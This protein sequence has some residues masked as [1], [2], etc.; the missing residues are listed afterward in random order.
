MNT[1]KCIAALMTGCLVA[2]PV[3]VSGAGDTPKDLPQFA[4]DPAVPVVYLVDL[5]SGAELVAHNAGRRFMPASVTKVMTLFVA[6]EMIAAGELDP[7]QQ[8]V[9]SD[10]V[11]REWRQKGSTMF[12]EADASVSVSDL[13]GGIANVSANDGAMVLAEGAGGS[14]EAWVARMNRTAR[15]LGMRDSRFGTPNGWADGGR[16]FTT[17]RDLGVL[18]RAMIERH[19]ELYARY[20]GKPGFT[21]N[22][23]TQS[24]HDPISGKVEGADGIKTGFTSEAGNNFLGS[25]ERSGRRLVLVVAGAETQQGRNRMARDLLEWGFATTASRKLYPGGAV[26]G[27]AMVQGGD[28]LTVPLRTGGLPVLATVPHQGSAQISLSIHYDGPLKA[29]VRAGEKV[30]ELEIAV[31]GMT[32]SRVPLFAS[33]SVAPAKGLDRLWNG[34]AG[35]VRW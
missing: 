26:V 25:A 33:N 28:A 7:Q 9:I 16:T 15:E 23:I 10:A 2:A 14:V 5:S 24:N 18:A 19:P 27:T 30:A 8:F 12:I 3:M 1:R 6:F 34:L 21:Y 20:I 35:L 4:R 22:G 31:D 32:S 13:L 29:P 17:A 11:F